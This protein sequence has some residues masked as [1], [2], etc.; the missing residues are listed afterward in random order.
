MTAAADRWSGLDALDLAR[1]PRGHQPWYD[2]GR[3]GDVYPMDADLDLY[4]PLVRPAWEEERLVPVVHVF[5]RATKV[6]VRLWLGFFR[7]W[8]PV[9]DD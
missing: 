7:M 8:T 5:E 3:P 2:E 9:V 6:G 1:L 4:W